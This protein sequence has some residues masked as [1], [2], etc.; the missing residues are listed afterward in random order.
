MSRDFVFTSESVTRGHPDKLCDRISD[1]LVGEYLAQDRV[2][3][4][5]AE[6]AVSTGIVFVSVKAQTDGTIDIPNTTRDVV[7]EVGYDYGEFNASSCTVMTSVSQVASDSTRVCE[8]T[9]S[10]AQLDELVA[11]EQVT[12]FG[13]ACDHTPELMPL[14]V[15]LAHALVRRYDVVSRGSLPWLAPDGKSQV[16]VQFEDHRPV[17]IHS[18][19]MLASQRPDDVTLA[20]VRDQVIEQIIRPVFAQQSIGLKDK[21]RIAVN[22]EGR[23]ILGGPALHAGLTGR[24]SGVD[25]YGEFSRHSGSAL[26]GKDPSRVERVG[27]YA[28]RYAAKNVVAAELATRCEVQLSYSIGLAAPVSVRLDTFGTARIDEDEIQ[29]RVQAHIDFRLGAMIRDLELRSLFSAGEGL[30]AR[31]TTYGHMGRT[32]LGVPWERTDLADHLR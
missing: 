26:S 19:T 17:G 14:P 16:A 25:S 20:G 32:D 11:G 18:V 7:A 5:T 1:A 29:R 22:P 4:V 31:L 8:T 10:D 2:S 27:A 13:F 23:I 12:V 3:R 6:C 15:A 28:A 24:K 30:P 9:L 21:T